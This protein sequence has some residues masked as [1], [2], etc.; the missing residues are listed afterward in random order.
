MLLYANNA[1]FLTLG[2]TALGVGSSRGTSRWGTVE[3][4]ERCLWLFG[5][6]YVLRDVAGRASDIGGEIHPG[7]D[8]RDP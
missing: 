3:P 6:E 1:M 2:G 5:G 8:A 7:Q 4:G